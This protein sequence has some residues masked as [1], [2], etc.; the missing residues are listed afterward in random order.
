MK[1]TDLNIPF[2][3]EELFAKIFRPLISGSSDVVVTKKSPAS[4]RQ[5]K[6][7]NEFSLFVR[8]QGLYNGFT[9]LRK[10]A[11]TNY[12]LTLPFGDHS[13]SNGWPGTGFSAFVYVNAP[14][15]KNDLDLLLDPPASENVI[16]N[17]TF[18]DELA[19]WE[20]VDSVWSWE[21]DHAIIYEYF[22]PSGLI[23]QLFQDLISVITTP[24]VWHLTFDISG[25]V[26]TDGVQVFLGSLDSD[27]V[28]VYVADGSYS[29]DLTIPEDY[30]FGT[31]GVALYFKPTG[32]DF[33]VENLAIDNVVLTAV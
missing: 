29:G 1:L 20:Q 14:R 15:F 11:W 22:T 2:G 10:I 33:F 23:T 4:T 21:A 19:P 32:T 28:Q 27:F 12:W 30:D 13:G 7:L 18:T 24:S 6:Y 25:D 16:V 31:F 26:G 17:G 8:W 9:T 5:W 3:L